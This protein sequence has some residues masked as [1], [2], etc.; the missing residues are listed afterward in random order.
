MDMAQHAEAGGPW[1]QP[2]GLREERGEPATMREK[3][4]FRREIR[5]DSMLPFL[6]PRERRDT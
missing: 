1:K 6:E 5:A 3:Q 4:G 2:Q